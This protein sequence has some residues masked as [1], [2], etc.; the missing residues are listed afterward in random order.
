MPFKAHANTTCFLPRRW[1]VFCMCS[2]AL[3]GAQLACVTSPLL[4]M[5]LLLRMSGVPL[6]DQQAQKRWGHTQEYQDYVART[7]LLLPLPW[8]ASGGNAKQ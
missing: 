7:H 1:G 2:S 8:A 6:Q 4:V 3:K 5:F